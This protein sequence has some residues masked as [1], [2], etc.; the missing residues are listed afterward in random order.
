M[1]YASYEGFNRIFRAPDTINAMLSY[2]KTT[3]Q[4][5]AEKAK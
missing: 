1:Q 4:A 2:W 3:L 5:M